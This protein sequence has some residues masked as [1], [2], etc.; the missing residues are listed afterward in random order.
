MKI[1]RKFTN[2]K[3]KTLEVKKLPKGIKTTEDEKEF[4]KATGDIALIVKKVK[5]IEEKIEIKETEE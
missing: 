1:K 3:L 5:K 2:G 4:E